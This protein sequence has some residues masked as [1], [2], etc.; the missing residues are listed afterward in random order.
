MEKQ[1]LCLFKT[2]YVDRILHIDA[3]G[4]LVNISHQQ[5]NYMD[6]DY[7]PIL[8]YFCLMKNK[9][10][11]GSTKGSVLI[12]H[13]IRPSFKQYEYFLSFSKMSI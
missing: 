7:Q 8:N 2:S 9:K 5:K 3:T 1:L 11:L 6:I 4:S 13:I 12:A 10:Y